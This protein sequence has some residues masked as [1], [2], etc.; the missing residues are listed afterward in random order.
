MTSRQLNI[1]L[2][3]VARDRLEAL[4]FV[5]RTQASTLARDVVL[6][7]LELHANESG[8]EQALDALIERDRDRGRRASITRL[9]PAE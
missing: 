8:L 5:R 4:A 6:E 3:P 2:S 7:Y 9:R 1:R